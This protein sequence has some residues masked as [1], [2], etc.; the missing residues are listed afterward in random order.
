MT[1]RLGTGKPL[2]F[3]TVYVLHTVQPRVKMK[4]EKM[5]QC[6]LIFATK[7]RSIPGLV[8]VKEEIADRIQNVIEPD[9]RISLCA[10]LL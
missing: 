10:F 2:T 9:P 4:L 8:F 6:I 7:F 5:T 3:F 1:S